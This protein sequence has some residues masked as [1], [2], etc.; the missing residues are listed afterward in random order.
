M[1]TYTVHI[2]REMRVKFAGVEAE[3][4]AE[5]AREAAALRTD[6][7]VDDCDGAN[8]YALVDLEGDEDF[9]HS[10]NVVFEAGRMLDLGPKM[11]E[12]L[13]ALV[14][15]I[16]EEVYLPSVT[17]HFIDALEDARSAIAAANGEVLPLLPD[18]S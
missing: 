11:Q 12:V 17:C 8:L 4:I 16:E 6:D 14:S 3:S 2:Y 7:G 5:A 9:E 15:R 18:H 13:E 10:E 1:P